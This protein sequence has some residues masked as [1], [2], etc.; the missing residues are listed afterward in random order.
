MKGFFSYF[1][2]G[3]PFKAIKTLYTDTDIL[4]L[5]E[6]LDKDCHYTHIH[7]NIG[8]SK[9]K[10]AKAVKKYYSQENLCPLNIN[11]FRSQ[12]PSLEGVTA[13]LMGRRNV[14]AS[15]SKKHIEDLDKGDKVLG[16][17]SSLSNPFNI[18][19]V[20][21]LLEEALIRNWLEVKA[22]KDG[23]D[24]ECPSC[25]SEHFYI[26]TDMCCDECGAEHP[27]A[28]ERPKDIIGM[29]KEIVAYEKE[30]G[31]QIIERVE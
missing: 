5:Q 30:S 3:H 2:T 31:R 9:S 10:I 18:I 15:L 13:A 16:L 26:T 25:G 8:Y 1:L 19:P 28:K 17:S 11:I 12:H 21:D 20:N 4:E 27:I 23:R 22:F 6:F 29:Y 24:Q 14:S 7:A